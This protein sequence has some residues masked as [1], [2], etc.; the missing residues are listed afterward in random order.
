M[1]K[2]IKRMQSL[3]GF[4]YA[5]KTMPKSYLENLKN[6]PEFKRKMSKMWKRTTATIDA[7]IMNGV[8][9][10][11]EET[12]RYFLIEYN[13]RN[14][15]HGLDSMPCSFNVMEAFFIHRPDLACFLLRDEKDYLF[16]TPEFIDF[17]TSPDNNEDIR[18]TLN[19][20]EERVIYSYS[21]CNDL[22]EFIFSSG[23]SKEYAVSGVS[24]IRHDTEINMIMLAGEKT[25]LDRETKA[26]HILED[27]KVPQ[28][29]ENIQP[30]PHWKKEA[31]L[32][33]GNKD[34]WQSLVL[35]R[36]D[37]SDATQ[38]VRY[39][40]RDCGNAYDIITDDINIFFDNSGDFIDETEELLKTS[41]ERLKAYEPLLE[42]C[43]SLLLLP[44]Y[45]WFYSD[46]IATEGHNTELFKKLN[47]VSWRTKKKFLT[48]KEMIGQRIVS[49]LHREVENSP[50]AVSY[51]SPEIKIERSGF[52]KRLPSSKVGKD[53]NGRDIHGRTW[54]DKTFSWVEKE[55]PSVIITGTNTKL[56]NIPDSPNKGYIYVM[57]SASDKGDIYKIG[58]TQRLPEVRASEV[59]RGTGVPTSYLVVQDWEVADCVL[60]EKIIHQELKD[61]RINEKREFFHAPYKLLREVIEKNVSAIN[62]SMSDGQPLNPNDEVNW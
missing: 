47:K 45:F 60:A 18:E 40:M 30:D 42:V 16:S 31:V 58:L 51:T 29:K 25:D 5:V 7:Q 55:T 44:S 2:H 35:T 8:K 3:G 50:S 57:R 56:E 23:N 26:L 52:W 13:N 62:N 17:A 49:V 61:Y 41:L 20:M 19:Y 28:G 34:F 9:F 6:D 43:K 1:S 27:V 4:N 32:L 46:S 22:E 48:P 10:G 54:V 53:K 33:E 38:D 39:V 14:F 21:I 11:I 36:F 37:L 24:M 59:S 12:L 15:K